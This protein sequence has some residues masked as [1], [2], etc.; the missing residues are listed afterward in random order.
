ME[1]F[2][3][4]LHKWLSGDCKSTP[5]VSCQSHK[6]HP[7][8]P[9]CPQICGAMR[10]SF[11]ALQSPHAAFQAGSTDFP[12]RE[13]L[14]AP[15]KNASWDISGLAMWSKVQERGPWLDAIPMQVEEMICRLPARSYR[16]KP[17]QVVLQLQLAL[18][19]GY[20][21][22]DKV[23]PAPRY[24]CQG[25]GIVDCV[26]MCLESATW[27]RASHHRLY[28]NHHL[29]AVMPTLCLMPSS[30]AFAQIAAM[31]GE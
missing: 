6:D 13:V 22:Q 18:T 17:L 5:G 1:A 20:T 9:L 16:M 29:H 27:L 15:A 4:V 11:T 31:H 7:T 2:Q 30:A 25:E 26:G 8:V 12:A 14:L 19:Y 3:A 28:T 10:F 23:H 21:L 24:I